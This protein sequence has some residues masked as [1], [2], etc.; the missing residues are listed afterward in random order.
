MVSGYYLTTNT[1]EYLDWNTKAFEKT[2]NAGNVK[3]E[4]IE[5]VT[6]ATMDSITSKAMQDDFNA[7]HK[8]VAGKRIVRR[9]GAWW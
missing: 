8:V 6:K 4:V 3:V 1:N 2:T 5:V 9:T 7:I